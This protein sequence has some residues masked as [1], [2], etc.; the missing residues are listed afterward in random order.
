MY[1]QVKK[2]EKGRDGRVKKQ[3]GKQLPGFFCQINATVQETF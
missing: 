3:T 1:R 2:K